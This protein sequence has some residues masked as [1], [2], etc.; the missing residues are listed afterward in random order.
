MLNITS[1]AIQQPVTGKIV[2][3]IR[4]YIVVDIHRLGLTLTYITLIAIQILIKEGEWLS[5]SL[6]DPSRQ[7]IVYCA[8]VIARHR[9]MFTD[10]KT[11]A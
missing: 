1:N 4:L 5:L 9:A 11:P 8:P 2:F 7:N 10:T 6:I 3:F